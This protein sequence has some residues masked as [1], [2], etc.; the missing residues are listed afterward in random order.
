[1]K[2]LVILRH[3][4]SDWSAVVDDADRPLARRGRKAAQA[5]GEFLTRAGQVP[6]AV[7]TSVARRAADT[8]SLAAVAGGWTCELR[9]SDALYGADAPGVLTV[10]RAEPDATA[11]LLL[12][13]HE[14]TASETVTL[15][16]GGGDHRVPTAAVAGIEL[17]VDRW[18][19][20]EPGCG[21]LLYRVPPR[22]VVVG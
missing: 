9:V 16:V 1:M 20:V 8:A 17:A 5:M 11:R 10:A 14:P 13:G 2:T 6:D 7:V 4:K 3:G 15:L 21:R 12:V 22:L 18:R 19:D